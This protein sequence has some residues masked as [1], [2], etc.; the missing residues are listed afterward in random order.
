MGE[1]LRVALVGAGGIAA[2]H[3]RGYLAAKAS[4]VAFV[5][6]YEVTRLAREKEWGVKGYETLEA[7]LANE[8]VEAVSVCSPNAFHHG[9]TVAAVRA[10]LHVLCE[11]PLSMSLAE[12][13]QMI[14]AAK[15]AK[16]VLQTGHHLR[17]NLLVEKT[18][19]LITS[20]QIGKVAFMRLRQAHDWG[21]NKA[22][23]ESFGLLKNS[24]GGT[25]LDNGCHMMDLARHFGGNVRRL[26]AMM[27]TL[28]AWT[29]RVEVEDTSLVQLEF[30]G[31]ILGSVENAWT[32]TGWEEG[33][34]IYGTEGAIEC[35]NRLG[36]RTLRHVRRDSSGTTWDKLDETVYT[37]ADEGGHPRQIVA[38]IRS[39]REGTPVVCT[40]QDGMESVRLVLKAYESAKKGKPVSL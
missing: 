32:A 36:K 12:C 4:V 16:V 10:G 17:S 20:G 15:K 40:G 21:G 13:Q 6:P 22:V 23:R 3:Y 28:G 39:I 25:L 33:W 18:K 26:S 8:S 14:D 5:E 27:G 11:K 24:G 34:W 31:G 9:A 2:T 29:T 35:T 1:P 38:F 30:E 19:Q 37:Y 7:L